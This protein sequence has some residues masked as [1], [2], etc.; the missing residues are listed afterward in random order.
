M[1]LLQYVKKN[2]KCAVFSAQKKIIVK[3]S[4]KRETENKVARLP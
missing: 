1:E 4:Y 3:Y 2:C